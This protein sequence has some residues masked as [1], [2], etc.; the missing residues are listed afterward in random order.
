MYGYGKPV[1]RFLT[2][3]LSFQH[4]TVLLGLRTASVRLRAGCEQPTAH[5]I[6]AWATAQ[7]WCAFALGVNDVPHLTVVPGLRHNKNRLRS[8]SLRPIALISYVWLWQIFAA[9][10]KMYVELPAPDDVAWATVQHRC[11]FAL[12]VNDLPHLTGVRG[13][14]AQHWCL[15]ALEV[16]DLPHLTVDLGYGT[17]LSAPSPLSPTAFFA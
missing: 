16:Y 7:H 11:A 10:F 4:L 13:V 15:F 14:S 9:L 1:L 12:G 2:R 6:G 8:R 5:N 17:A 3:M